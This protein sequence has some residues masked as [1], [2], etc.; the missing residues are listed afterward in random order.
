MLEFALVLPIFMIAFFGLIDG[1]RLVFLNSAL[2]QAAREAARTGAVQASWIASSDAACGTGGGPTC[3]ATFDAFRTNVLAAANRM[4]TPFA[5]LQSQGLHLSC[6]TT[7]PGGAWTGQSCTARSSGSV[8]SV[9]V[10][11]TFQTL[12]PVLSQLV[13]NV[14]LSGAASMVVN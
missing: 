7:A 6:A 12:T 8:V 1:A 4:M 11:Q 5:D 13:G 2:S 14:T 10:V 3:P 9:R